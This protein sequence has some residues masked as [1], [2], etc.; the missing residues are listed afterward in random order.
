MMDDSPLVT[1]VIVAYNNENTVRECIESVLG[2]DYHKNETI[3]VYDEGSTDATGR[4]ATEASA[5]NPESFRL[6][7]IP[8]TG[9]SA[10]RNIGWRK[11]TGEIV[12][13]ADADDLYER[14]YLRRAVE[15]FLTEKTGCVCVTGASLIEGSGIAPRMLKIYSLVQQR[16]RADSRFKPTWAWVYRRK[17][18]A[19]AGGFDERLSQAEDKDLFERVKGL[20]YGV[21]V[22]DGIHWFHRRPSSNAAYFKKTFAGGARRIPYLAKHGDYSGFFKSTGI[23]WLVAGGFVLQLVFPFALVSVLLVLAAALAYRGIS[24]ALLIWRD[25]SDK[26]DLLIYPFFTFISHTVSALGVLVGLVEYAASGL[27]HRR[28]TVVGSAR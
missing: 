27:G 5:R 16:I 13:F 22:V 21:Q 6:V 19:E 25:T 3:V 24:T 10:A 1:S 11:G 23:V 4:R 20:G 12:F 15:A 26:S 28:R 8:H 18:L 2:Q 7:S 9:R 14:D 17:A